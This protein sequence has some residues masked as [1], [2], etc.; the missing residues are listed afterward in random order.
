MG[1]GFE[2][3]VFE[4]TTADWAVAKMAPSAPLRSLAPAR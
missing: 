3:N 1:S 2:I 4:T